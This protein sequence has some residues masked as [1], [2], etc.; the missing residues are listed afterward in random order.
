MGLYFFITTYFADDDKM[1]A[2]LRM[3]TPTAVMP[4]LTLKSDYRQDRRGSIR[5]D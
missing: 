3:I 2:W 5:D 1:Q 4:S